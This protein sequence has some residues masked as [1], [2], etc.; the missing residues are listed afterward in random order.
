M[1]NSEIVKTAEAPNSMQN[2]HVF[3]YPALTIGGEEFTPIGL[4]QMDVE[5]SFEQF[6]HKKRDDIKQVVVVGAW[7]G[8]EI[9]SFIKYPNANIL[10]FEPNPENFNYLQK[11]FENNNRVT[12]LPYACGSTDGIAELHEANATGNDSLL[13]IAQG[14]HL[15]ETKT[16]TV[17][18]KKLDNLD[19]LQNKSIDLLWLDVQGFELEVLKGAEL[20]LKTC[21]AVFLEVYDAN[22]DYEKG[23]TYSE[24]KNFLDTHGFKIVSEGLTTSDQGI[25]GGNAF[26]VR[27]ENNIDPVL[28]ARF[29]DRVM[30]QL[31]SDLLKRKV[32]SSHILRKVMRIFSTEFKIK[33][34][35]LLGM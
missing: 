29:K 11:R 22:V 2:D 4:I 20:L 30:P 10:A 19:A 3:S 1:T 17:S 8:D 16:H 14:S 27:K 28:F 26:L 9:N 7:R 31:R 35:R 12:C 13:P 23:A 34:K 32:F 33:V 25:R 24:L 6:I 15:T 18:V 5:S 21:Q